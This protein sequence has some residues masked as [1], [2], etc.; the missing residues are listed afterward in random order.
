MIAIFQTCLETVIDYLRTSDPWISST[1]ISREEAARELM[2][3][4]V[5][6]KWSPVIVEEVRK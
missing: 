6:F 4:E 3:R 1:M 5:T 2:T